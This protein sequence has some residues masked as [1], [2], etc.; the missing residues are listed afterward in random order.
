MNKE[1]IRSAVQSRD[2]GLKEYEVKRLVDLRSRILGWAEARPGLA[3][4]ILVDAADRIRIR[5]LQAGWVLKDTGNSAFG[6]QGVNG[7]TTYHKVALPSEPVGEVIDEI[8][9]MEKVVKLPE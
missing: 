4:S 3:Q 7:Q 6:I 8:L 9:P 2:G 5:L 1:S